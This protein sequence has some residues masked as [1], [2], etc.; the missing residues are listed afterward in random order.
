VAA[1]PFCGANAHGYVICDTC[2]AE[3]KRIP[4]PR[5]E[6]RHQHPV[7]FMVAVLA[8]EAVVLVGLTALIFGLAR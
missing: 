3:L 7:L 6:V 2:L 4:P 1:C 5:R 8:V